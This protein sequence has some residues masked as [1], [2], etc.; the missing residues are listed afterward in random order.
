MRWRSWSNINH[1]HSDMRSFLIP[2]S[3]NFFPPP[4]M[5]IMHY[6]VLSSR[7]MLCWAKRGSTQRRRR[8]QLRCSWGSW[9]RR[10]I[11]W[12]RRCRSRAARWISWVRPSRSVRPQRD[13]WSRER[14][15]WRWETGA[16]SWFTWSAFSMFL[17]SLCIFSLFL[18]REKQQVEEAL[19]DVRRNE[20]EMCQSNQSLLTRLEDV[21]V[22][23]SCC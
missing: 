16:N 6:F 9:A 8:A 15:S 20:E 13:C 12:E 2:K 22:K 4:F 11:S 23:R 5:F 21:Q 17:D 3:Y 19:K 18:Q 14:S 7:T 10:E 1:Q